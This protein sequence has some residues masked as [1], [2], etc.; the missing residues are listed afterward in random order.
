MNRLEDTNTS[1]KALHLWHHHDTLMNS[2]MT[3]PGR[4]AFPCSSLSP[5][6][7][8]YRLTLPYI[9][10]PQMQPE[11]KQ[12]TIRYLAAVFNLFT[13]RAYA[14]GEL[15]PSNGPIHNKWQSEFFQLF[16]H[17][18]HMAAPILDFVVQS[19]V[20]KLIEIVEALQKILHG[21]RQLIAMDVLVRQQ[22][23]VSYAS[24][25]YV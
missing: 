20:F 10:T 5:H 7:G 12:E 6:F 25:E 18:T 15:I 16:D 17:L 13:L 4:P 19:D 24:S 22:V 9:I 14:G 3:V 21:M 11:V 1:A 8:L 23:M 2:Y